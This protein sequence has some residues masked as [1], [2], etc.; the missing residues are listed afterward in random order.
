MLQ[1]GEWRL[2]E[3]ARA[4]VS[5]LVVYIKNSVTAKEYD[6]IIVS[7]LSQGKRCVTKIVGHILK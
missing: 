3:R 6:K 4:D 7:K 5:T 1:D 2:A